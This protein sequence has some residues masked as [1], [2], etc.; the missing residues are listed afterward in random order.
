MPINWILGHKPQQYFHI[1][2]D[3]THFFHTFFH[4]HIYQKHP[5]NISQTPLPKEPLISWNEGLL[6]FA[7]CLMQEEVRKVG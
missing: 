7:F 6:C 5:N 3:I 1:L 4:S 2:N